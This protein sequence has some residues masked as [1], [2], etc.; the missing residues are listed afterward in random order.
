[1]KQSVY[2]GVKGKSFLPRVFHFS[3]NRPL[4]PASYR[5]R[6]HGKMWLCCFRSTREYLDIHEYKCGW[7]SVERSIRR[8]AATPH[9]LFLFRF[10]ARGRPEWFTE[11]PGADKIRRSPIHP[12]TLIWGLHLPRHPFQGLDRAIT[13]A[14]GIGIL[15]D[16]PVS[17]LRDAESGEGVT[18]AWDGGGKGGRVRLIL[19]V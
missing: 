7:N 9:L 12:L 5:S 10:F 19:F 2:N 14:A 16:I 3:I 8:S 17:L 11:L 13:T 18:E 4:P 1:M 6:L 15:P